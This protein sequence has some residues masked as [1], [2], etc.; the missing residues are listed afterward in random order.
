[1]SKNSD[2]WFFG[3]R[4]TSSLYPA[5]ILA[6][7]VAASLPWSTS[8]PA[9]LIGLWL[10]ALTPTIDLNALGRLL[11]RPVCWLPVVFFLLALIGTSWSSAPW[12]TRAYSVGPLAKLLAIPLLIYHFQRSERSTWVFVAFFISCTLLMALSWIVTVE[13]RLALKPD[14]SF[15][16]PVKNYIDQSQEFALCTIGALYI[17]LQLMRQRNY[18]K[19]SILIFVVICFFANMA[20]VVVSRTAMVT[21]PIMLIA[22]IFL[23]LSRRGIGV[24]LSIALICV[25]AAWFASPSLRERTATFVTQYHAYERSNEATSVGLRLEFWR[26]SLRFWSEAPFIGNG[27]GSVRMLFIQDAAGQTGASAEIIANPHNQTLYTAIQW[28]V[29]GITILY[30]MWLS[31][32]LL[33]RGT[34]LPHWIGFLVVFQNILTS[35]F[36]SHLFDFTP[37][38]I[39]VLGV[40]VAG[41]MVLSS[42]TVPSINPQL[43]KPV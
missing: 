33:F 22:F 5:D 6:V 10:I 43:E 27:T 26:K 13:P 14:A 18:F 38:W 3:L 17:F 21:M 24:A 25:V 37:G 30:A 20:F 23:H 36:N 19:A 8:I 7:L 35:I 40:G 32:L 1:M 2:K 28:G 41:G 9:I 12:S 42:Q 34:S 11:K 4:P 39:Y 31:H 29:L 16:V 15:G